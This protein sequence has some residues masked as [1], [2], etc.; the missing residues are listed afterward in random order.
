MNA[1]FVT[2]ASGFVGRQCLPLLV[3][4]GYEVHAVSRRSKASPVP[5]VFWHTGNLLQPGCAAE[6]LSRLR[7]ASL[8]HLAWHAVPGKFSEARENLE[9]LRASLELLLAFADNGGKRFVG[10][11]TCAEY[12]WNN[13]KNDNGKGEGDRKNDSGGKNQN[14]ANSGEC[15]E[16][17]TPLL[18]GTLYGSSKHSLE[19]IVHFSRQQIGL[20]TA[21]GRIF[22]LYGPH[23]HPVRLVAYAVQSLLRGE[24]A[25][26]SEGLQLR[27]FLHVGDA[28]AALVAVLHSKMEGP[29]NIASG[30]PVS[31][32]QVLEEIGR[33]TSRPELLRFGSRPAGHEAPRIW[34]NVRRLKEEVGFH[35]QFD[36]TGGIGQTIDWWRQALNSE[37]R[38]SEPCSSEPCSS[39]GHN[40]AGCAGGESNHEHRVTAGAAEP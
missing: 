26:C 5:G 28:A 35:P 11:G 21:W 15:I 17:I 8:L 27:D 3:A 23:E 36:L 24:P 32:R 1:V 30:K 34:A 9:W 10:A 25:F 2:G 29:V 16:D 4:K 31:I 39:E 33:Q 6:L 18:P 38:N 40:L 20:S 12:E 13:G 19:R 37:E 14:D 7:P 22:F